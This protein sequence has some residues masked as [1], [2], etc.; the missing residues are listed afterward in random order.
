[1]LT[2]VSNNVKIGFKIVVIKNMCLIS[3]ADESAD[4]GELCCTVLDMCPVLEE[5]FLCHQ[6]FV[7]FITSSGQLLFSKEVTK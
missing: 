3:N 2:Y 6:C 7:S 4:I 5:C 1:M